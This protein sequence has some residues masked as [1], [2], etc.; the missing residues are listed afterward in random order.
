MEHH[1]PLIEGVDIIDYV[2][3]IRV[4]NDTKV[5]NYLVVE[6]FSINGLTLLCL[7]IYN[8]IYILNFAKERS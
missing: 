8:K 1:K 6:E 4:A 5:A 3:N 2:E 7:S